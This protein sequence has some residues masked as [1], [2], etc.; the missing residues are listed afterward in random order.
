[1]K[2]RQQS[3]STTSY[4][5]EGRL[6][7]IVAL[8]APIMRALAKTESQ[9][10]AAEEKA[11][12]ALGQGGMP[13]SQIGKL[14]GINTQRVNAVLKGKKDKLPLKTESASAPSKQQP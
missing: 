3:E 12:L 13:Q 5:V 11:I 6:D 4:S 2:Q 9:V 7:A 14:L 10:D 1:M 8:L